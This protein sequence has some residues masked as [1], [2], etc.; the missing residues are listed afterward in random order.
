VPVPVPVVQLE[1]AEGPVQSKLGTP[2]PTVLRRTE[3]EPE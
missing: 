2:G 3:E 1:V